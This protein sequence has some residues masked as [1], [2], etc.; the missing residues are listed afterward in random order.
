[1]S[2]IEDS[3]DGGKQFFGHHIS[4]TR[5]GAAMARVVHEVFEIVSIVICDLLTT[6]NASPGDDPDPIALI[7]LGVAIAI[8]T[9]IDQACGV[10][11]D[12]PVNLGL[13]V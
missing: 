3:A 2:R 12:F 9:V 6:L 4:E 8:A 13:L 5:G 1:M 7:D 11:A 10:P